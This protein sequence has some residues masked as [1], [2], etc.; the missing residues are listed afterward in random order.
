[1][2]NIATN[3]S[4]G[5]A[6]N[7]MA[8]EPDSTA[9]AKIY[10]VPTDRG[11]TDNEEDDAAVAGEDFLGGEEL[12]AGDFTIRPDGVFYNDQRHEGEIPV[13]SPLIVVATTRNKDG[14]DWGRLV[15]FID[16]VGGVKQYHMRSAALMTK[17]QA[18][19]SDLV[20]QGLRVAAKLTSQIGCN[21]VVP[22]R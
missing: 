18:V 12:Q 19:I 6:A 4:N 14:N 1:M 15:R 21:G 5:P 8:E 13:C 9:L 2:K 7:T 20:H 10:E 3:E 22:F 17:P 16:P 11:Q